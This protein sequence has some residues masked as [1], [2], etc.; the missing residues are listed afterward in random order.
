MSQ[1]SNSGNTASER[2]DG[3]VSLVTGAAHGLGR[4]IAMA[5]RDAGSRVVLAVRDVAAGRI[6]AAEMD[7]KGERTL[8]VQ[9]DITDENSVGGAADA[10]LAAFGRIDTLVCNSGIAGPTGVLWET[11]PREWRAALDVN[12][13]GTY[14]T[15][16]AVAPTMVTSG[17]GSIV[18]IG[19]MTAKRV[20]HGRSSYMSS[21]S[22]L[23]GL[24]RCLASELGVYGVRANLVSPGAID[25]PR[26]D[27]VFAAQ[28]QARGITAQQA[29]EEMTSAAPLRRLVTGQEVAATTVFLASPAA[30]GITGQD[31]NVSAGLVMY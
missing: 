2:L 21:K 29:R 24:I 5:L 12:V 16:R 9:C 10:A 23:I 28:A 18:V 3:T 4:D 11:D 31:V 17:A 27:R 25:G 30:S 14:L 20:L 1:E 19:S 15:C 26:M 8:V 7:Q 6:A 13:V 22:A